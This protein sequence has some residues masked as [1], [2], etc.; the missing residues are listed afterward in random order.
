MRILLCTGW[1]LVGLVAG[2]GLGAQEL[3]AIFTGEDLQGWKVP[4]GNRW[5]SAAGGVLDV[6]SGPDR[7]GAILWTE[8]EYGDFV[9]EFEFRFGAG[10]VD[11]GIFVRDEREQIQIGISGS[12]KRDMTASPYISG[13][14]YPVEAGGAGDLLRPGGWNEMTIMAKG[15]RY[16]VWLNGIQV[17]TYQSESAVPRGPVGIQLHGNRDMTIQYRDIRLARLG[18]TGSAAD[19]PDSGDGETGDA[20]D[21]VTALSEGP[22]YHWFGYYDKF[23]FDPTNRYVLGMRVGFEQR[24]PV[25]ADTI[26]IG[27]IDRHQGN[28]WIELGESR[29]WC[30][31]QGCMLQWRP[32]SDR[33]VVWNDRDGDRFV[34]R[35]L[36]TTTGQMRTLPRPVYHLSPDGR[37]ALGTDFARIQDQRPGYGYPGVTDPWRDINAPAESTIYLMDL[38]SGSVRDVVSLADIERIRFPEG[39]SPGKM[40]FNHIQF[41]PDGQRFLFL[42]RIDGNRNTHAYTSNLQGTDVRFLGADSSHFQWRDPEHVLIWSGGAYRLH[43][44]DGTGNSV[45]VLEAANGHHSYLPNPEWLLTDTYPT[46]QNREQVVCLVHL[47]SGRQIE[48]GRFHAPDSYAGSWR[49]DTHPRLSRDGRAVVVDSPHRGN[50]RQMYLIDI[51]EYV[52]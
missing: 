16:T 28:R 38:D 22:G 39:K 42:N 33:D 36:D 31:Q 47:P 4:D 46:G 34:C 10:T 3:P 17:M 51:S 1:L 41:S 37:F 6:R 52:D 26:R 49:C 27:M 20:D 11:S 15:D 21:R 24:A 50:G 35:I 9:M 8:Q 43:A 25:A 48:I 12:L 44:D 30:W 14:G 2:R 5:F 13:K 19:R 18:G 23:Q 32:G 29:A 7:Q 45:V 40:H